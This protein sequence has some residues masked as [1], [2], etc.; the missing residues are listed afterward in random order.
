MNPYDEEPEYEIEHPPSATARVRQPVRS[1][2]AFLNSYVPEDE[3]LYDDY[4][5]AVDAKRRQ[6]DR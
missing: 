1:H 4:P 3:G 6:C 2:R 5:A